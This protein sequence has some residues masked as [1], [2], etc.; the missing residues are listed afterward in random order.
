MNRQIKETYIILKHR[1]KNALKIIDREIE[2][3]I[4][5][6]LLIEVI[7]VAIFLIQRN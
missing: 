6:I 1:A 5:T 2:S 4:V 3:I 7:I